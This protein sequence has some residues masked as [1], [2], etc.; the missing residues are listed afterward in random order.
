M[1]DHFIIFYGKENFDLHAV[2]SDTSLNIPKLQL[3]VGD[4]GSREEC[5]KL[6]A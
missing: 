1:M 4:H 5:M 3:L 2:S 6:T